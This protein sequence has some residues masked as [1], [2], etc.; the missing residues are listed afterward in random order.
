MKGK[1]I[2]AVYCP[3]LA[4]STVALRV[5]YLLC[6]RL[7]SIQSCVS[8]YFITL[9]LRATDLADVRT[10]AFRFV[11]ALKRGEQEAEW[12]VDRMSKWAICRDEFND[13]VRMLKDGRFRLRIHDT[14][15]EE[16]GDSALI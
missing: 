6:G 3:K 1:C 4:S 11:E 14:E 2:T 12:P 10:R 16:D 15:E 7:R 13:A 9:L 8:D 5:M